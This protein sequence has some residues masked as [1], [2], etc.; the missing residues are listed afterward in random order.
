MTSSR[1]SQ[2]HLRTC[3]TKHSK[4]TGRITSWETLILTVSYNTTVANAVHYSIT[5]GIN[6]PKPDRLICFSHNVSAINESPSRLT[7]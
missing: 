1:S 4:L 5:M 2:D 6:Y 7:L 3:D